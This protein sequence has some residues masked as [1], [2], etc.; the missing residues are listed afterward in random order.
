[1]AALTIESKNCSYAP[2]QD[3]KFQKKKKELHETVDDDR[4]NGESGTITFSLESLSSRNNLKQNH[5]SI[6]VKAQ[7]FFVATF[8]HVLQTDAML[9]Q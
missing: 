9:V 4:K 1:M 8:I 6:E 3:P 5:S 7:F 2:F